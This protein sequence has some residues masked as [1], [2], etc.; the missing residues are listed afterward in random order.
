MENTY[1]PKQEDEFGRPSIKVLGLGGGG[2]NAVNRMIEAGVRGVEYIVANTDR[3]HATNP[4]SEFS[5]INDTSCNLASLNLMKFVD[6]DVA[7]DAEAFRFAAKAHRRVTH[8][9]TL[10]PHAGGAEFLEG[11][12]SSLAPLQ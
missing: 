7:F 4:C 8:A 11:F 6:A 3:Q 1:Q 5:F 9:R 12:L 2:G 10:P